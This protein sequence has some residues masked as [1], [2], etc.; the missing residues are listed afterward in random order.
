MRMATGLVQLDTCTLCQLG[1]G[2]RIAPDGLIRGPGAA[3]R[4]HTACLKWSAHRH[5][6]VA[7]LDFL[8]TVLQTQLLT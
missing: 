6:A 4:Q 3:P 2:T 7:H 1:S 5:T 8:K